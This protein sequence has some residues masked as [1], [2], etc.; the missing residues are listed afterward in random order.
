MLQIKHTALIKPGKALVAGAWVDAD[1]KQTIDV[2]NPASGK[3]VGQ[4]PRMGKAETER[5]YCQCSSPKTLE[6][7]NGQ[8]AQYYFKTLV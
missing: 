6:D 3:V 1:S 8:R 4:V 7:V 5:N 2:T